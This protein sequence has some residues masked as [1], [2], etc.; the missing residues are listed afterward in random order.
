MKC[1]QPAE[2]TNSSVTKRGFTLIELLVVIAI[3]AIL[4][5]VL[6]PVFAQARE[7]AR[8]SS[9]SSNLKQLGLA[10]I[11]YVNDYDDT[12]PAA[13]N[14][15]QQWNYY[16][17][18]NPGP[19][20][21]ILKILPYCKV[22][23]IFMCPDDTAGGNTGWQGISTSY[24]ANAMIGYPAPTYSTT[25]IGVFSWGD[26]S[27]WIANNNVLTRN[28]TRP[29]TTIMLYESHGDDMNKAGLTPAWSAFGAGSGFSGASWFG[30]GTQPPGTCSPCT[31]TFPN[32]V[33]GGVST[34][35]QGLAT[36]LYA[37]GHVKLLQPTTTV[38]PSGAWNLNSRNQW[39]AQQ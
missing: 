7:K 22:T 21:W 13:V 9:C 3:I 11:Q 34:K 28:I 38:D 37:D 32:S 1:T 35:H 17:N 5:A 15:N 19:N 31:S 10:V 24:A 27:S 36:F 18:G 23:G 33:N 2:L 16:A 6:F 26:N 8:Q 29:T 30:N 14:T 39:Y 20:N 4:A 25:N 12:Y